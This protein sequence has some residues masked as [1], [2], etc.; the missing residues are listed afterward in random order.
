MYTVGNISE[1][2]ST[3]E[4]TV[5]RKKRKRF[6]TIILPRVTIVGERIPMISI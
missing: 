2:K 3:L 4:E 6:L 1:K 5:A